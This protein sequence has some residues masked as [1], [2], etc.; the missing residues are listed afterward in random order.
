MFKSST[1]AL[2]ML[3]AVLCTAVA[4]ADDA[5]PTPAPAQ[6]AAPKTCVHDTGTRIKRAP[7]ECTAADGRSYTKQDVDLTGKTNSAGALRVL[8][9]SITV[10]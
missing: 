9:P 6:A 5:K 1:V 7:G 10:H 4:I 2:C 3:G 8:D